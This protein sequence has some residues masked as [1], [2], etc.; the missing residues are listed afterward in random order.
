MTSGARYHLGESESGGMRN[1]RDRPGG[2]IFCHEGCCIVDIGGWS[3]GSG[4]PKVAELERE[5][6]KGRGRVGGADLEIAIRVEE[7]I[8]GL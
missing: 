2:D 4:K 6:E 3:G 1:E 5:S 8:R 7:E